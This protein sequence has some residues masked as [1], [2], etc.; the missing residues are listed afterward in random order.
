[1]N[2]NF[3]SDFSLIYKRK[4]SKL[5]I[6][7]LVILALINLVSS[8]KNKQ[9]TKFERAYNE[10]KNGVCIY[11][12]FDENCILKCISTNCYNQIFSDYLIEFGEVLGD[13]KYKFENCYNKQK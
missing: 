4:N 1:M 5:L 9:L 13:L 10:C 12:Q 6:I 8:N 11:R 7:I 2:M 3:N